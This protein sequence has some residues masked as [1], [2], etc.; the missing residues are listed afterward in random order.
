[1]KLTT[2]YMTKRMI[3][4][5]DE[6]VKKGFYANRAVAIRVAIRDLLILHQTWGRPAC[7]TSLDGICPLKCADESCLGYEKI[8]E[9]GSKTI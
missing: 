3:E 1:M 7:K 2:L 6:V 4:A 8:A 5:L 9:E